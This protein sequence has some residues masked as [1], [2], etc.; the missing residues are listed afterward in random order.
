MKE[1]AT[2]I[3]PSVLRWAREQSGYTLDHV[4][5]QMGKSVD[6]VNAWENGSAHPTWRQ[7]EH[8]VR[9]LYHRPTALF[10]FPEPPDEL[11]VVAEFRRQPADVLSDLEPDTLYAIR[12][13]RALQLDLEELAQYAE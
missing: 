1:L 4:A 10:F 3:N 5:K 6:Q 13:A 11:P 7:F 8:L 9:D 12:L 2:G